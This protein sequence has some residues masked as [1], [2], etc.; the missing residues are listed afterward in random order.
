[1]FLFLIVSVLGHLR[2]CLGITSATHFVLARLIIGS[3]K[4]AWTARPLAENW[5]G[6]WI[7]N[8]PLLP[9]TPQNYCLRVFGLCNQ[10]TAAL[11]P[12]PNNSERCFF[13]YL[14]LHHILLSLFF[15]Y[16]HHY[17]EE[18]FTLLQSATR[19]LPYF[20]HGNFNVTE[21]LSEFQKSD[22]IIW[23]K[24]VMKQT[25]ISNIKNV[26]VKKLCSLIMEWTYCD[27]H[28][29][30]TICGRG[31][32]ARATAFSWLCYLGSSWALWYTEHLNDW[33]YSVC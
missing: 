29:R 31:F 14:Q 18:T 1:M 12:I 10:F 17:K 15:F 24:S 8:T 5:T 20:P 11:F 28:E 30:N 21:C 25:S 16:Y 27:R 3:Y 6:K 26:L 2:D 9:L 19:K 22:V 32:H 4:W 7:I 13:L 33:A 23:S